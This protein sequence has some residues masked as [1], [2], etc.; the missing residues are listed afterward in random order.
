MSQQVVERAGILLRVE[1][2]KGPPPNDEVTFSSI[3]VLDEN[4]RA[5]GPNLVPLLDPMLVL[6]DNSAEPGDSPM[7][8]RL[9][10]TFIDE[11]KK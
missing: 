5:C 2:A 9:L 8:E 4:Y 7:A 10:S 11:V 3:H 6:C 1:F